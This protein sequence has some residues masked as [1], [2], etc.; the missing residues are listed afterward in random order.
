VTPPPAGVAGSIVP[1]SPVRAADTRDGLGG[2]PARPVGPGERVRIKVCGIGAVPVSGVTAVLV[3]LTGV[4]PTTTTF[5]TACASGAALPATSN[6][7]PVPG[8]AT[9]NLALVGVGAD[10]CIDVTNAVGQSHLLAD[11][12]GYVHA[13]TGDCITP[14]AP[15]RLL[16]TRSGLG[17][18]A[19]RT[20]VVDLAVWDR[21]GVPAGAT[22]VVLN[23]TLTAIDGSGFATVGPSGE[24]APA[25]S[26]LNFVPGDTLANLV[27]CKLGADGRVR[28]TVEGGPCHVIADVTGFTKPGGGAVTVAGPSRVVDTRSGVGAPTGRVSPSAPV[29]VGVGAPAGASGVILNLTALDAT[30]PTFVTVWPGGASRPETSNLNLVPGAVAANLVLCRLGADAT[31]ELAPGNGAAHL[32][33]DVTG[34]VVG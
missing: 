22:G 19:G 24:P 10:G 3:N 1:I 6:L 14:V 16:D 34:F 9:P 23:V 12:F 21:G 17:A 18:P 11:V 8:R 4:L 7:N 20:S 13:T 32:I 25:T 31:V 2:V 29:R 30:E 28:I 33:A 15:A 26:N 27:A 5:F